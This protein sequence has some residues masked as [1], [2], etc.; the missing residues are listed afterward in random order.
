MLPSA[1]VVV[2]SRLLTRHYRRMYSYSSPQ[3]IL[4]TAFCGFFLFIALVC[5]L[6]ALLSS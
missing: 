6:P 3:G 5:L 2:S 1:C 4:F